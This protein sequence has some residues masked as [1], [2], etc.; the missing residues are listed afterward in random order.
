[1]KVKAVEDEVRREMLRLGYGADVAR[2]AAL[3][4]RR[5]ASAARA[6]AIVAVAAHGF[7]VRT[8]AT[9]FGVS[10]TQICRIVR[11]SSS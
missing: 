6:S 7:S 10:K 5:A 9:M 4:A 1:M 8:L 3:S 11:R 2:R